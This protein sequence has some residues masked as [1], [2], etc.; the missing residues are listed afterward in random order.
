LTVKKYECGTM[1]SAV[2]E[3]AKERLIAAAKYVATDL[4]PDF[5]WIE[6]DC[7]YSEDTEYLL[8]ERRGRPRD[9][10]MTPSHQHEPGT[11]LPLNTSVKGNSGVDIVIWGSREIN[12]ERLTVNNEGFVVL[13]EKPPKAYEMCRF[14]RAIPDMDLVTQVITVKVYPERQVCEMTHAMVKNDS[15]VEW[16]KNKKTP[17]ELEKEEKLDIVLPTQ[18]QILSINSHYTPPQAI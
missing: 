6:Q 7:S 17:E 14:K 5:I 16:E 1:T 8:V 13:K 2:L 3:G 4:S 15:M 12:E 9:K 11:Y 10:G 18:R